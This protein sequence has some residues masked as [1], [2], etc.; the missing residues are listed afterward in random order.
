MNEWI[1]EIY[2]IYRGPTDWSASSITIIWSPAFQLCL[3]CSLMTMC[4]PDIIWFWCTLITLIKSSLIKRKCLSL[5]MYCPKL[6]LCLKRRKHKTAE[7][8]IWVMVKTR[9][10]D[11]MSLLS[12]CCKRHTALTLKNSDPAVKFVQVKHSKKT[13]GNLKKWALKSKNHKKY[14]PKKPYISCMRNTLRYTLII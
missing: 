4:N 6:R 11:F 2:Q 10:D 12:F 3:S 9:R 1:N 14:I 8:T 13:L 5:T 7:R